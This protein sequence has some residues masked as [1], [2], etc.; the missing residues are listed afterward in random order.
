MNTVE[1]F[2]NFVEAIDRAVY[3]NYDIQSILHEFIRTYIRLFN[4][5]DNYYMDLCLQKIHSILQDKL[6]LPEVY[7]DIHELLIKYVHHNDS[8]RYNIFIGLYR[9]TNNLDYIY[10]VIKF[11]EQYF[12]K[13]FI[14]ECI[15]NNIIPKE[16]I[17]K[18]FTILIDDNYNIHL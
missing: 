3:L 13:L 2:D 8:Y 5:Q 4:K 17:A 10:N 7:F 16:H 15:N 11:Y 6:L 18:L 14:S 12:A 9:L 1:V